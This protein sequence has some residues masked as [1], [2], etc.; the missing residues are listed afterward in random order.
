VLASIHREGEVLSETAD[1]D[2]IRVRARLEDAS[3][4]RLRAWV[5]APTS[6]GSGG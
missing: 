1:A 6:S 2:G 4:H 3:A 5:V